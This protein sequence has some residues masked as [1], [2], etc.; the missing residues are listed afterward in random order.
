M[1]VLDRPR[2]D[3]V[4][5]LLEVRELDDLAAGLTPEQDDAAGAGRDP[6]RAVDGLEAG[7]LLT[8]LALALVVQYEDVDVGGVAHLDRAVDVAADL[9]VADLHGRVLERV[10]DDGVAA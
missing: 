5:R 1:V 9:V 7:G 4:G 6:R 2:P 3:R 8:A 10:D